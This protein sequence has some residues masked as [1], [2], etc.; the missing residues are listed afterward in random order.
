MKQMLLVGLCS[1]V[2]GM[3]S[4]AAS[5]AA[6]HAKDAQESRRK[7]SSPNDGDDDGSPTRPAASFAEDCEPV[8]SSG[9]CG[10]GMSK[11]RGA[12]GVVRCCY[13]E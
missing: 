10:E 3:P 2:F 4:F 9:K 7:P 6:S 13:A 8:P 12:D 11:Q 5:K 1:L